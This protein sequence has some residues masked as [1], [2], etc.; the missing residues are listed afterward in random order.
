VKIAP[1]EAVRRALETR[2]E[3]VRATVRQRTV[4]SSGR[5]EVVLVVQ[6]V[7]E[8]DG[9]R[10]KGRMVDAQQD[11]VID[12]QGRKI[13]IPGTRKDWS[14]WT[15]PA[16]PVEAAMLSA[17]YGTTNVKNDPNSNTAKHIAWESGKIRRA[18]AQRVDR[19]LTTKKV[20]EILSKAGR[21]ERRKSMVEAM[22]EVLRKYPEMRKQDL[23][24]AFE[25]AKKA[26]VVR[27]VMET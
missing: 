27:E 2:L 9:R 15:P 17:I 7:L 12:S 24:L 19:H 22:G 6:F 16:G 13:P 1:D 10:A 20:R 4:K 14:K 25:E 23:L 11:F 26:Q 8:C 18:I 21:S 3:S 5:K